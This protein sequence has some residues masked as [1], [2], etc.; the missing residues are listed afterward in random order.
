MVESGKIA[1]FPLLM[2]N[3]TNLMDHWNLTSREICKFSECCRYSFN[4]LF[5]LN[6]L[7]IC[8]CFVSHH[9][10]AVY[11][12]YSRLILWEMSSW[13]IICHSLMFNSMYDLRLYLQY[14]VPCWIVQSSLINLIHVHVKYYQ[15]FFFFFFANLMGKQS[16]QWNL[17]EINV[18]IL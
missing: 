2:R 9:E 13:D 1:F 4:F 11:F 10:I 6:E 7:L 15:I 14:L 17:E 16:L 3:L 12:W 8:F 18:L 5:V